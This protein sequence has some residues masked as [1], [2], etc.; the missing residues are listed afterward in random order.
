MQDREQARVDDQGLRISPTSSATTSRGK[1]SKKRLSLRMRR[2][3]E[4]GA[5][6]R[7][8]GNRCEEEP[9]EVPQ[10]GAFALH[11]TKLLEEGKRDDLR[12]GEPLEGLLAAGVG[13]EQRVSIVYEAEEGDDRLFRSVEASGMVLVG[14]PELLW[15][16]VG[17]RALFLSQPTTQQTSSATDHTSRGI[18]AFGL[19]EWAD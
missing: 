19:P 4:E 9:L 10:E 3:S 12:V 7:S 18:E 14:H 1:D 8:P 17:R 5:S 13:I 2:C 15:S 16:G 11:P 6:P